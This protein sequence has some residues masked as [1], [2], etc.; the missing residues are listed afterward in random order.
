MA[1]SGT[2]GMSSFSAG[3]PKPK[4]L[5]RSHSALLDKSQVQV[6]VQLGD[7]VIV[8]QSYETEIENLPK[9][10]YQHHVDL[11]E[12]QDNWVEVPLETIAY[13]RSGDKGNDANVGVMA[14]DPAYL[15]VLSE[16]VTAL[17]VEDYFLHLLEGC[18]ERFC[19]PGFDAYNFLMT[20][21]LGGGGTASIR[22]DSQ[23]KALGQMLLS[24]KVRVPA[25]WV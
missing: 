1:T 9:P 18:V 4:P 15:S 6:T 10:K 20:E 2:P 3:R 21:A 16:Q 8:Q 13:A 25:E 23:G 14:R 11:L 17:S 22:I 24:M 5:M 12:E 19:V 7:K